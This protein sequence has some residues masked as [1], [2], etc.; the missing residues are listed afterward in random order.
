M[1]AFTFG[2]EDRAVL[3]FRFEQPDAAIERLRAAGVNV[4]GDVEI[5]NRMPA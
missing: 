5:Y 1:Y 2:H 4:L 3:I